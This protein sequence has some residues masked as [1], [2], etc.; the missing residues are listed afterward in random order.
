MEGKLNQFKEEKEILDASGPCNA[1][2][3]AAS[4]VSGE[5]QGATA[6]PGVPKKKKKGK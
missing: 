2:L 1:S 6:G 5:S 3:R 4:S